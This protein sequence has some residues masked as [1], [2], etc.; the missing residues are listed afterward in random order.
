MSA[1]TFSLSSMMLLLLVEDDES[2]MLSVEIITYSHKHMDAH[3]A[4]AKEI[5]ANILGYT[6]STQ[7]TRMPKQA[8]VL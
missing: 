7:L 4:R 3:A 6:H 5:Y 1:L 8:E 2:E